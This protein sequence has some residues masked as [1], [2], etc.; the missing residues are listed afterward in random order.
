MK[1]LLL[2]L[3]LGLACWPHHL[4]AVG[5]DNPTGVTGDSDGEIATGGLYS[6]YTGNGKRI[7]TDLEVAGSVG[8]YPLRWTRF[9]NTRKGGRGRGWSHSYQWGAW[10][11]FGPRHGD[12]GAEDFYEGPDARVSWKSWAPCASRRCAD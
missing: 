8:A 4:W 5:N 6:A 2:V 9:L 1:R 3:V 12:G 7:V 11:R 10:V